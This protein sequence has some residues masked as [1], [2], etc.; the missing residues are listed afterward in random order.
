[1][2]FALALALALPYP[3]LDP[4]PEQ[5]KAFE[6]ETR[7]VWPAMD[8]GMSEADIFALAGASTPSLAKTAEF[9]CS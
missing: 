1:M 4:G 8:D 7:S 6:V 2:G 9:T 3:D 5:V